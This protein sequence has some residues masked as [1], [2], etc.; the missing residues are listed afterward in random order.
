MPYTPI[1][2]TLGYVL[3]PDE[4][5]VLMIH[6]NARPGDQTLASIM[7]WAVRSNPPKTS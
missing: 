6:R 5:S 4:R 2:A 3:S 7:A 1:I